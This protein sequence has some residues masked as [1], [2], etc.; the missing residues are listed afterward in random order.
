MVPL[1]VCHKGWAYFDVLIR[2][3]ARAL[4]FGC[5]LCEDDVPIHSPPRLL[6]QSAR[7]GHDD[8]GRS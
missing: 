3:A 6:V 5:E 1:G 8:P 7:C 2:Y 4:L